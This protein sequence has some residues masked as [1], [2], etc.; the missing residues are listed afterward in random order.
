[1]KRI[2]LVLAGITSLLSCGKSSFLDKK[3]NTDI[4]VPTTPSDFQA[5]LDNNLVMSGTPVLGELSADNFY[6]TDLFWQG[7][8]IVEHNAYTWKQDIYQGQGQ[9]GDWDA[10]YQQVFYANVVLTGL[11]SVPIDTGNVLQW[12]TLQG[13]ALFMRAYA[14]YNIAQ[15]FAPV[16]D[17]L[18]PGAGWGIPLRED[19]NINTPTIRS[20][21]Q[22]TY[23]T[24][25]SDLHHALTLLPAALPLSNRNR[26]SRP[27]AMALLARVY[28][29]MRA[30]SLAGLYADSCLQLYN[31]LID[32][33]S[34][35]TGSNFPFDKLNLE[36][37][38]QS[39]F[40]DYT[41]VLKGLIYPGCVID[42]MLYQSYDT[43]DLRRV[44]FYKVNNQTKTPQIKGSYSGTILPFSGLATDEVYLIRA[45]CAA[46]AGNTGSAMADLNRLLLNRWVTGKFTPLTASSPQDAKNK[47]LAE[48]RKELA[49]RGLRWSDLRRLNKE[50][51]NY[52]LKRMLYGQTYQLPPNSNLYILPIPPD[53]IHMSGIPDNPR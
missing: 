51:A 48:R 21:V 7:L 30:Y 46:R 8:D 33:N 17:S 4:V 45:E 14:F 32:Y 39:N 15:L 26:A 16:Y 24:I 27:A 43:N 9:I 31:T 25:L 6:L 47:I 28:L 35:N 49:F 3:P 53:V 29:S 41:G 13:S 34:L 5:L 2:C 36:T 40:L 1:M 18:D 44:I 22:A 20:S 52:T 12:H 42:S 19:P 23:D 38:Y 50:G 37:L 10:P 11:K